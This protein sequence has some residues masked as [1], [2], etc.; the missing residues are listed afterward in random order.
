MA[1]LGQYAK[2]TSL[3]PKRGALPP[4]EVAASLNIER[5]HLQSGAR[6]LLSRG[7]KKERVCH[8]LRTL[9]ADKDCVEVWHLHELVRA[10]YGN[11]QTCGSVWACPVCGAKITER[12]KIELTAALVAAKELGWVVVMATYTVRHNA[13]DALPD[14]LGEQAATARKVNPYGAFLYAEAGALKC[15][16]QAA[17]EAVPHQPA[18]YAKTGRLRRKERRAQEA[19]PYQP[20]VYYEG[21]ELIAPPSRPARLGKGL[22][23]ARGYATAGKAMHE[24]R[25]RCG[26]MGSIRALELTWGA[27]SGWHPHIHE[28]IFLR[29]SEHTALLEAGLRRQWDAGLRLAGMRDVNEHGLSFEPC[30][31]D[32]AAYVAKFGH[33]RGW[34]V[35]HEITK[36][37]V[38]KGREGRWTPME[39]LRAFTLYGDA[40]AGQLWREYALALKGSRQLYWSKGLHET[41]LGVA[42][43]ADQEVAEEV[44][45]K[46]MLLASLD[47][48]QWDIIKRHNL[49]A[50]VLNIAANGDAAALMEFVNGQEPASHLNRSDS[51]RELYHQE[52]VVT[53]QT[54]VTKSRVRES[55]FDAV[56]REEATD[57]RLTVAEYR[58]K[59]RQE[60]AALGLTVAKY[61]DRLRAEVAALG[62]SV[63]DCRVRQHEEAAALGLTLAEHLTWRRWGVEAIARPAEL[64]ERVR[65][66]QARTRRQSRSRRREVRSCDDEKQPCL[67]T[68]ATSPSV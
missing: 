25:E 16:A 40:E 4:Q 59:Q 42:E 48:H 19:V 18:V 27:E 38:K 68:C 13:S 15:A 2:S 3:P 63:A 37:P 5:F 57:L 43:V 50:Q 53:R 66:T 21:G 10:R 52:R 64:G 67:L 28:L 55:A 39:L 49:R 12:R 24:L 20:A 47:K 6:A 22:I 26:V 7:E 62:L 29:S 46:G 41:L 65:K 34:N 17:Q 61:R 14:L 30:D 60:A 44:S 51:L 32:I 54:R 36:Q 23:G 9:Q 8:C 11:L 35:E 31:I 58:A 45:E 33:D 56:E 1:A